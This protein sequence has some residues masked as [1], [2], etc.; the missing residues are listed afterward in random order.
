MNA[1]Q[2]IV[3]NYNIYVSSPADD[4]KDETIIGHIR[5]FSEEVLNVIWE[6]E[7]G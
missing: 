1:L 4:S 7:T 3:G 5:S 2:N 6:T